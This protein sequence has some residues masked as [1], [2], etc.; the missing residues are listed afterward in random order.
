MAAYPLHFS[1][2]IRSLGENIYGVDAEF[3][4]DPSS[5]DWTN[6][7]DQARGEE[8]FDS[9]YGGGKDRDETINF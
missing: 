9:F 8:F 5:Q 6:A 7:F 1:Q 3:T 4:Y 2:F